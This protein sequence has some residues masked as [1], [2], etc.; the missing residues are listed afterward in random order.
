MSNAF[1]PRNPA[2]PRLRL[3][4]QATA[5]VLGVPL[6]GLLAPGR[7][8]SV[9]RARQLAHLIA[10]RITSRGSPDIGHCIGGV[11][12][13]TVLYGARAAEKR[14]KEDADLRAL[15]QRVLELIA[16]RHVAEV[17]ARPKVQARP[18]AAAVSVAAGGVA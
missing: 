4:A 17:A 16:E 12:H 3:I 14:L 5:E 10:C 11:E 6:E 15:H 2:E 18:P 1:K 9:A 8:R 7:S 13:T